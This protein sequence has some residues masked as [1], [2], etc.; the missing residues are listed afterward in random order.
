[1]NSVVGFNR[2]CLSSLNTTSAVISLERLAGGMRLSAAF[3][4]STLAAVSLDQNGVRG[5][6]FGELGGLGRRHRIGSRHGQRQP[7]QRGRQLAAQRQAPERQTQQCVQS[8]LHPTSKGWQQGR[9]RCRGLR[10]IG[11][12][13]AL[14]FSKRRVRLIQCRFGAA[15]AAEHHRVFSKVPGRSSGR[16][17]AFAGASAQSRRQDR[18]PPRKVH[19]ARQPP[20][21]GNLT[22]RPRRRI[23]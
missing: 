2:S 14:L 9:L 15:S 7:R 4:N 16:A 8:P 17:P 21:A 6:R 13:A 23:G 18:S 22:G 11:S 19:P 1:M 10:S 5:R 3:S 20:P 12:P